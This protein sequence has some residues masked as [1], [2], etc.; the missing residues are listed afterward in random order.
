MFN[1]EYQA[2]TAKTDD[3][4]WIVFQFIRSGAEIVAP[5][6]SGAGAVLVATVAGETCPKCLKKGWRIESSTPD[7]VFG[8]L[9]VASRIYKCDLCGFS[10]ALGSCVLRHA[11]AEIY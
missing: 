9:G 5:Q 4:L 1:A 2:A 10:E 6:A 8:D 7:S 11:V 3:A